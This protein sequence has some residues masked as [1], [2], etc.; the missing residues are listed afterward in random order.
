MN[1]I[2]TEKL[3]TKFACV[4]FFFNK[5]TQNRLVISQVRHQESSGT[6]GFF[7]VL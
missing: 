6:L 2:E 1:R 3:R 7:G 5:S 4:G